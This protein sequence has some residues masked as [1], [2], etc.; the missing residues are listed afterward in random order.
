MWREG[1]PSSG[2]HV[3]LYHIDSAYVSWLA[4][5]NATATFDLYTRTAPFG[6]SYLL[7]AGLELALDFALAFHFTDDDLAYLAS[8]QRYDAAFLDELRRLRFTGSI[9]AMPEGEIAFPDEP[10]LRVTAPFREALLLESGL[11]QSIGVSTLLATKAARIVLAARGRSIAEFGY[12]RAQAPFL[13]ARSAYI[14]GCAST[15]FLAAAHAFGI[16]SSGTVPHSLIE[17]FPSEAAAFRAVAEA[18]DRYALLID[19]YD[20]R[21]A[22]GTA[23]TIAREVEER[24]GHRLAAVR[25]DSGD[26]AEQSRFVRAALDAAGMDQVLVLVSGD[27]DEWS[28]AAL[29]ATGAPIDGF[30]VGTSLAT[31]AG[32]VTHGV[33]GG[34]L[35][36]VYKLVWYEGPGSPARVKVAGEKSTWPGKKQIR[37]QGAFERDVIHLEGESLAIPGRDLLLPVVLDGH[38]TVGARPGIEAI[39]A[40]AA[41]SL[42]ALPSAYTRLDSPAGYPVERSAGSIAMREQAIATTWGWAQ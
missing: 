8:L 38:L 2:L 1:D 32:S 30:G 23:I 41:A 22:I 18:L 13:A 29:I 14:A 36:A 7:A 35:G 4:G 5:S 15:S 6:G 9:L 26:L 12:R 37:R 40:R 16:P 28:I 3:D 27:L 39:R 20:T 31:G 11:L 42:A 34:A 25:I 24:L 10:L 17:A 21:R 33:G 19:T